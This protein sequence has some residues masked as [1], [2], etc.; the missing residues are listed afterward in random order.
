M[1]GTY[2]ALVAEDGDDSGSTY[3]NCGTGDGDRPDDGLRT[4]AD[5]DDERVEEEEAAASSE[6]AAE[7]ELITT[8]YNIVMTGS[9]CSDAVGDRSVVLSGQ[10]VARVVGAA[11]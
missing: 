3:W 9:G 11:K 10:D 5:V 6:R 1:S 8:Y 7:G 4:T 2:V